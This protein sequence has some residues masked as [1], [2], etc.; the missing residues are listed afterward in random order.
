MPAP[1]KNQFWKLRSKHGR[2]KLF[3][4]PKLLMKA[5][6]EYFQWCD[7]N[8]DYII[9]QKKGNINIKELNITEDVDIKNML[10]SLVYIP[11][12]IP[13]TITGLCIFMG[14]SRH[15]WNEFKKAEH[16]GFLETI[17]RIEEII[18]NQKFQGAAVG[19]FNAS[20]IGKDLGL[21]DKQEL[22][23]KDG[24]DLIPARTLTKEE[25]R[26]FL[27]KLENEC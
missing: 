21:I 11:T 9:E 19:Y 13:Y 16:E 6:N 1:E 4:S 25:A 3:A 15:W 14:C 17:S 8:P 10:S 23:G 20:I 12:K 24:K 22:T 7:E 18:Y 27:S 2:D 5:A 26:E